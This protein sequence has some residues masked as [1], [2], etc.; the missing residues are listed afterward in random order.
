MT[1]TNPQA[2]KLLFR[3]LALTG[4]VLLLGV[5]P[6]AAQTWEGSSITNTAEVTYQDANGNSYSDSDNVSVTVGFTSGIDVNDPTTVTPAAGSTDNS[7]TFTITNTGN[8]DDQAV[9]DDVTFSGDFTPTNVSYW[10]GGTEY[11]NLAALNAALAA[12]DLTEGSPSVNVTVQY[13]VPAG[14]GGQTATV[15]MDVYSNRVNGTTDSGSGDISPPLSGGITVDD[16]SG[17]SSGL[18]S[19]G[20]Q[21][22]TVTFDVTNGQSGVDL[23]DLSFSGDA[24]I[25]N[26]QVN[27]GTTQDISFTAGETKTITV[28]YQADASVGTTLNMTL[29][30]TSDSNGTVTDNGAHAFTITEPS[31]S[32]TKEAWLDDKSAEISGNVLPGDYIQYKVIVSNNDGTHN[33]STISVTDDLPSQVTYDSDSDDSGSPAWSISESGGTVTATLTSL[34][35]GTSRFFWIRVQVN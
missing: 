28:T 12:L 4:L 15:Q 33:L 23:I 32:I 35:A 27:G 34:P 19:N 29:T 5:I 11:A 9:V 2:R 17:T 10:I 21:T 26:V 13:D 31:F 1:R 14:T 30:A 18:A 20:T 16:G 8:G 25:S 22:Y 7:L 24:G 6:A 3:S